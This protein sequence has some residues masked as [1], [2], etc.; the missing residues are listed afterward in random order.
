MAKYLPSPVHKLPPIAFGGLFAEATS[1]MAVAPACYFIQGNSFKNSAPGF[2]YQYA[3]DSKGCTWPGGISAHLSVLLHL[4]Q[5]HGTCLGMETLSII[6][7]S[8]YTLLGNFDAEDA[9][10]KQWSVP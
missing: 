2:T 8:N 5:V 1:C 9:G 10:V 4:L 7:S 6:V 3:A